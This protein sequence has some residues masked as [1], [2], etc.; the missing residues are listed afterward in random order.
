MNKTAYI[1][2]SVP[3]L[4]GKEEKFTNKCFEA[5]WVSMQVHMLK[6]LRKSFLK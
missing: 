4:N 5:N 2:L 6:S 1:P 3:Y